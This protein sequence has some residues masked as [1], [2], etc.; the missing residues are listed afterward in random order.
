MLILASKS[1]RRKELLSRLTT[2]F[3]IEVPNVNE[4]EILSSV[5]PKDLA[6]EES[7]L[8]AKEVASRFPNDQI[9]AC[10]TVV[11]IDGVPLGKPKDKEDAIRMLKLQSGKKQEV[12]S[13]FTFYDWSSFVSGSATTLVYFNELSLSQIEE[14]IEKYQPFDKAGAYG[15]QDEAGLISRIEGSYSNVMGLPL[16]AIEELFPFL[17]EQR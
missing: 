4:D 1:P 2:S 7:K 9:L 10:D 14:Y 8:K 15:I 6:L 5:S 13:G 16:E 3:R 17:R 11:L 12:I